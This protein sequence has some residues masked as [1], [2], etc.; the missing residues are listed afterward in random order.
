MGLPLDV[1]G[2]GFQIRVWDVLQKV[3]AGTTVSYTFLAEQGI[4]PKR[5][6]LE[7]EARM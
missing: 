2:T 1:C 7:R 4:E 6:L 3:S 5:A